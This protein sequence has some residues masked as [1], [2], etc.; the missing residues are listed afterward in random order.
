LGR[1]PFLDLTTHANHSPHVVL[2]G[3]GASIAALPRGDKYGR[4]LP[5]LTNLVDIVG[6][7]PLLEASEINPD[8]K[9]G[10]E[11]LYDS[12]STNPE[13][14]ALCRAVEAKVRAFFSEIV[15][16]DDVTL[17]DRLLAGLRPKDIIATFNWDPLLLQAYARNRHLRKLP[18]IV[19]LH[20]NV[21]LGF[22][23]AHRVKGY[24]SQRCNVCANPLSPSP[25]LLPV[26]DKKYKE[27]PLL[28]AEWALLE[29]ELE[30]A[31]LFTIIGYSAP[32]SDVAAKELLHGAWRRNGTNELAE[33]E[34]V[35][36]AAK[37]ELKRRWKDFIVR[38]HYHS[39]RSLAR[40]LLTNYPRRSC[41]A[42]A[43]ATLQLRPWA[44]RP[45]PRFRKLESLHRW[46]QPLLDEEAALD[47]GVPLNM[48]SSSA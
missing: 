36:I 25:L 38:S 28:A 43:W 44:S 23:E 20:G 48:W 40:S 37:R 45:M 22:C 39:T 6:L 14:F 4:R 32:T 41:E 9:G 46:A 31:Y 42:F 5:V 19:F 47:A 24:A 35:D 27:H 10:F 1:L 33:I 15:I 8:H 17:Y 3:A 13:Y 34:I 2:L 29:H 16:P 18:R 7:R 26:K 21:E 12:I 30:Y 11:A